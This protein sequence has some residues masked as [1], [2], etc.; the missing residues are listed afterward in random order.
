MSWFT[1]FNNKQSPR[2]KRAFTPGGVDTRLDSRLAP[3]GGSTA[4][5]LAPAVHRVGQVKSAAVAPRQRDIEVSITGGGSI[6]RTGLRALAI[7]T[8]NG[9]GR[10]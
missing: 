10:I 7:E 5:I 3:G 9:R 1:W 6:R 8:G 2:R 4:A